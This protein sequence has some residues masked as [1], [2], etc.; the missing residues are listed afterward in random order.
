VGGVSYFAFSLHSV[1]IHF[2]YITYDAGKCYSNQSASVIHF[3]MHSY[4]LP[5][6]YVIA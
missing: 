3:D 4:I 6:F 5:G 1:I 2:K